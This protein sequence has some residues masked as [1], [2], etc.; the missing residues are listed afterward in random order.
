[1]A[2][3]AHIAVENF[4]PSGREYDLAR[5]TAALKVLALLDSRRISYCVLHGY[6]AFPEAPGSDVDIVVSRDVSAAELAQLFEDNSTQLGAKVVRQ[7]GYHFLLNGETDEH[8]PFILDLDISLDCEVGDAYLYSGEDILRS[9]RR[10]DG[11]WIPAAHIQFSWY[12]ARRVIKKGILEAHERRLTF[13]F[14]QDPAGCACAVRRFFS[15]GNAGLIEEAARSGDWSAIRG[16]LGAL[17]SEL[18]RTV[19]LR[20]P[21]RTVLGKFARV[22]RCALKLIAPR[23]GFVLVLLGPDGAGKSS[24]SSAICEQMAGA[25]SSSVVLRFPPA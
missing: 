23:R 1:M 9:R 6:E 10:H 14:R 16:N 11:I 22:G 8:R 18:L 24:V 3:Q 7:D 25:F 17:H 19:Y 21:G 12:L 2:S 20:R 15:D 4:G 5:G 13:L